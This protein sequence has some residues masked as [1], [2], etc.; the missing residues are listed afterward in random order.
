MPSSEK[1]P[2]ETPVWAAQEDAE[3]RVVHCID[4]REAKIFVRHRVLGVTLG[5]ASSGSVDDQFYRCPFHVKVRALKILGNLLPMQSRSLRESH[6]VGL[7][8]PLHKEG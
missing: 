4:S 2:F 6:V 7:P 8:V 5:E 3:A 1:E